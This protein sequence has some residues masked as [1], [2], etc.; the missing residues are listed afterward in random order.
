MHGN[1]FKFVVLN[2]FITGV[3]MSD[4]HPFEKSTEPKPE[5]T[6]VQWK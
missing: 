6:S 2:F 5:G 1:T 3:I 4:Y